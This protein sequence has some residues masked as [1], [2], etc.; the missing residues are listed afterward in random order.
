MLAGRVAMAPGVRTR[1]AL[2]TELSPNIMYI[3]LADGISV[4][5]L[6]RL[7]GDE[8]EKCSRY[9][10]NLAEIGVLFKF[11]PFFCHH[12]GGGALQKRYKVTPLDVLSI[13]RY[14]YQY[15]EALRDL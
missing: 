8:G 9:H 2:F 4:T 11:D 12:W 13:R 15:V 7:G 3:P 14:H 5:C 1:F 6:N 10:Q